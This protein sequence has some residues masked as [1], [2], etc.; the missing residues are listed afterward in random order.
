VGRSGS[1]AP[2]ARSGGSSKARGDP[3]RAGLTDRL[4]VI[5]RRSR[6]HGK[7][8]GYECPTS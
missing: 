2:A 6:S 1:G 7:S 5:Q 4:P 3:G 8:K